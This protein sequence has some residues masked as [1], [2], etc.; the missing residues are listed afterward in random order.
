MVA[1]VMVDAAVIKVS[2]FELVTGVLM[3]MEFS[4]NSFVGV[5]LYRWRWWWR[6]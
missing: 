2:N 4:L 5:V 1:A 3:M 6:L